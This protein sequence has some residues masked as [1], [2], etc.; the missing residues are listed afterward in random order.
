MS[1]IDPTGLDA[2]SGSAGTDAGSSNLNYDNSASYIT[3]SISS[4]PAPG[5]WNAPSK[6]AADFINMT[7]SGALIT[8]ISGKRLAADRSGGFN[9]Q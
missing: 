1:K 3:G 5:F 8:A 9:L 7:P 6:L 2:V 4:A